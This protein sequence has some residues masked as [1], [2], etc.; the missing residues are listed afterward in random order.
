MKPEKSANRGSIAERFGTGSLT[1]HR[2]LMNTCMGFFHA[3]FGKHAEEKWVE[4][5][6]FDD[7]VNYFWGVNLDFIDK[8]FHL[9]AGLQFW[10][11]AGWEWN[12]ETKK[13]YWDYKSGYTKVKINGED[14]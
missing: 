4:A 2:I 13:M 5:H 11:S 7:G 10:T 6:T 3:Q 1:T 12:E 9:F 14:E 8:H